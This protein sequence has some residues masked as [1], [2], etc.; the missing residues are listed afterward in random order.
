MLCPTQCF[1]CGINEHSHRFKR[2]CW[3]GEKSM[4]LMF[5][6]ELSVAPAMFQLDDINIHTFSAMSLVSNWCVLM[7]YQTFFDDVLCDVCMFLCR[8]KLSVFIELNVYDLLWWCAEKNMHFCLRFVK[9][10]EIWMFLNIVSNSISLCQSWITS[11]IEFS[12]SDERINH[13][14]WCQNLSE[15]L[16]ENGREWICACKPLGIGVIIFFLP[17]WDI[18]VA[19]Y[20]KLWE[21]TM[22][23]MNN[24]EWSGLL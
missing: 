8:V 21:P 23:N 9:L 17:A 4:C 11:V 2:C 10:S 1:N 5:S 22:N 18:I 14:L 7:L 3:S 15:L 24:T 13:I 6:I 19:V 16:W 20:C 12:A